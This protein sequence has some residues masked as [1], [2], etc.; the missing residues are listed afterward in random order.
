M[1]LSLTVIRAYTLGVL[2][3]YLVVSKQVNIKKLKACLLTK[4]R[5]LL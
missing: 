4:T 5:V 3:V 2:R 1:I